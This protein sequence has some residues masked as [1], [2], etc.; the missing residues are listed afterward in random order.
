MALAWKTA[1]EL[2]GAERAPGQRDIL[3]PMKTRSSESTNGIC[4]ETQLTNALSAKTVEAFLAGQVETSYPEGQVLL[5]EGEL[6]N[7][8]F[9]VHSG[10]V[11]VFRTTN[12][13]A[14]SSH[15]AHRGAVLGLSTV[16]SGRPAEATAETASRARVAY[17]SKECLMKLMQRDA[18]FAY[19]VVNVLSETLRDPFERLRPSR[20]R[21]HRRNSAARN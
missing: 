6:S 1:P 14:S 13:S 16:V 20:R 9:V 12:G 10:R 18:E 5:D 21:R 2:I 7:G 11:K 15:M 3:G 4:G 19:R 17:L 8:I